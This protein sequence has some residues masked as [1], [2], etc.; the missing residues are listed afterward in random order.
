MP[1]DRLP[2][3]L[4][5]IAQSAVARSLTGSK[6]VNRFLSD[7]GIPAERRHLFPSLCSRGR[8]IALPGLAIDDEYRITATTRSV[9]AIAWRQLPPETD[10]PGGFAL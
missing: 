2:L 8:I 6:K 3:R 4:Q 5:A 7:R 1:E 9:L 10:D